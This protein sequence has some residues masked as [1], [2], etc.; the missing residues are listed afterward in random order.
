MTYRSILVRGSEYIFG[1]MKTLEHK[2]CSPSP[3]GSHAG[4]SSRICSR[5]KTNCL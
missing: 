5:L 2:I 3:A 4:I 1:S